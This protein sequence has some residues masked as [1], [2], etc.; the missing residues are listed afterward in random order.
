MKQWKHWPGPSKSSDCVGSL[1]SLSTT[2]LQLRFV[3]VPLLIG[4][5]WW[6]LRAS[7]NRGVISWLF[8]WRTPPATLTR[9]SSLSLRFHPR[10]R[11]GGHRYATVATFYFF[12]QHTHTP[13]SLDRSTYLSLFSLLATFCHFHGQQVCCRGPARVSSQSRR[14]VQ[15]SVALSHQSSPLD[16][17]DIATRSS[18]PQTSFPV[19]E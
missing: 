15:A 3:N 4:T 6:I 13:T 11:Y 8:L 12:T 17:S 7:I 18:E 16:V 9:L 2:E 10:P 5:R 14:Q 1:R 19:A